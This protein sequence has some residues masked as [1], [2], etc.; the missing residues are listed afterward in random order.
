MPCVATAN[1]D[2]GRG[3]PGPAQARP[4]GPYGRSRK[5]DPTRRAQ[6]RAPGPAW[7]GGWIPSH[8]RPNR[9]RPAARNAHPPCPS[10]A[11]AVTRTAVLRLLC[12]RRASSAYLP[13]RR[14][15]WRAGARCVATRPR[16]CLA[17]CSEICLAG[18]GP[19]AGDAQAS[20]KG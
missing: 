5:L 11:P 17:L 2:A 16:L 18:V 20:S 19:G 6:P 4:S 13:L 7:Q 14:T 1:T 15:G 8:G 9:W 10:S 12:Y 3:E